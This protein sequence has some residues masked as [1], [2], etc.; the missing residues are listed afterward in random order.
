MG[1]RSINTQL[2]AKTI[3]ICITVLVKRTLQEIGY[4]YSKGKLHGRY[5]AQKDFV[6][7]PASDEKFLDCHG[8]KKEQ[9]VENVHYVGN[10]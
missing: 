7:C 10:I 1:I 8:K 5:K 2:G 6:G 9:V 4:T 3:N